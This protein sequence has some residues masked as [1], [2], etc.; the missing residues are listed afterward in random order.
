MNF[1]LSQLLIGQIEAGT[2]AAPP[3]DQDGRCPTPEP[4]LEESS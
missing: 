1:Q 3:L 2:L 4:H